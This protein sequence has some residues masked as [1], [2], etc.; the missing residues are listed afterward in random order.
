MQIG[1]INN[2]YKVNFT[3]NQEAN[4]VQT[5]NQNPEAADYKPVASAIC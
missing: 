4:Q 1:K 5:Q 3:Q 2:S